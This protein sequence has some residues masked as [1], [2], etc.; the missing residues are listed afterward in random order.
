MFD[1]PQALEEVLGDV[2]GFMVLK[3]KTDQGDCVSRTMAGHLPHETRGNGKNG[4]VGPFDQDRDHGRFHMNLTMRISFV[5]GEN[6]SCIGRR[7]APGND[8]LLFKPEQRELTPGWN[9]NE[10][11]YSITFANHW[12]R[13]SAQKFRLPS[14]SGGITHFTRQPAS[15]L[16][17]PAR[18]LG[19]VAEPTSEGD[20]ES[21]QVGRLE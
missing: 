3:K 16:P 18:H 10:Q 1:L 17:K 12:T 7:R 9:C 11:I 6:E 20:I 5:C 2:V 21:L 14:R 8:S 4:I 13:H 19:F 15:K